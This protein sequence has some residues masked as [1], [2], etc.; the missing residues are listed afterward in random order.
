ML[1]CLRPRRT[2]IAVQHIIT[3][4]SCPV[5]P[6]DF[7]HCYLD[8]STLFYVV[9]NFFYTQT[10]F[11]NSSIGFLRLSF[12]KA[13]HF[14]VAWIESHHQN[15]RYIIVSYWGAHHYFPHLSCRSRQVVFCI[16]LYS[17]MFDLNWNFLNSAH[18]LNSNTE[19]QYML[20]RS[21]KTCFLPQ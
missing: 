9:L 8:P 1:Q 14:P 4:L 6:K 5:I 2:V 17:K 19:Y 11:S 12:S 18:Y 20:I 15:K 10:C 3:Q 16:H 7:E 21:I 13:S